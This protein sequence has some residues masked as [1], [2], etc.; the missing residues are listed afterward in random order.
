MQHIEKLR[1]F[2]QRSAPQKCPQRRYPRVIAR[3]LKHHIG[4]FL[5]VHAAKFPDHDGTAVQPIAALAKQHRA[6]R[7]ELDGRRDGQQWQG[8]QQQNQTGQ[9]DVF[10]A[11]YQAPGTVHGRIENADAGQA[12]DAFTAGMQQVEHEHVGNQVHRGGGVAQAG[13]QLAQLRLGAEREGDVHLVYPAC[14]G[15]FDQLVQITQH[16]QT[17]F[18]SLQIHLLR[19]RVV[20]PQQVQSHPRREGDRAGQSLA[21]LTGPDNCHPARIEAVPTQ[22]VQ[23]QA[24][25]QSIAAQH[26]KRQGEPAHLAVIGQLRLVEQQAVQ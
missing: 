13:N 24:D 8:D 16:W 10:G 20:K 21:D 17:T 7:G 9:D 23:G 11:L 18:F 2:I 4:V 22:S 26:R 15:I 3:C 14:A 12:I 5:D 1:Q 19:V 6:R 25:Q